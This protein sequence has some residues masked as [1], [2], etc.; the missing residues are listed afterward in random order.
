MINGR[1][2]ETDMGRQSSPTMK[3]ACV[4]TYL[5]RRGIFLW[6]NIA[7]VLPSTHSYKT[8][9]E[10]KETFA[11]ITVCFVNRQEIQIQFKESFTVKVHIIH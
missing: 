9:R 6:K 1:G 5:P 11:N 2:T 10:A 4:Q 8:D 7:S 3:D